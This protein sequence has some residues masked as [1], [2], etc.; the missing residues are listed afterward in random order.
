MGST[1][2]QSHV[3]L[4][5]AHYFRDKLAFERKKDHEWKK[6]RKKMCFYFEASLTSP[7]PVTSAVRLA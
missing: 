4:A 7:P 6:E 5:L 3:C 2:L 1:H